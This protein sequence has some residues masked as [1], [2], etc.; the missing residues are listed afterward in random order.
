MPTRIGSPVR[1][2]DWSAKPISSATSRVWSTSPDVREENSESGTIPTMNSVVEPAPSACAAPSL[3]TASEMFSPSPGWIRLP[4]TRPMAR[5]T[6]DML[7][8]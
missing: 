2:M 8:K 6:V 3:A 5:A 1:P 4:T 7:M